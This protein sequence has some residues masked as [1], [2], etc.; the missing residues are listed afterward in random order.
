MPRD[1][2]HVRLLHMLEHARE[3]VVKSVSVRVMDLSGAVKATLTAK[4]GQPATG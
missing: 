2:D 1:R 3:A 4:L